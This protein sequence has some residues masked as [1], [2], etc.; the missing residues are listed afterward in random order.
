MTRLPT[1]ACAAFVG[2]DWAAA[3]PAVCLQAAGAETRE[4]RLLVHTPATLDAWVRTLRQRC[5][6]QPM[7]RCLGLNNG[8]L[9][10]ALRKDD[11]LGRCPVNP[12]TLAR[13]REAVAPSQATDAPTD[14]ERQLER[15]LTHRDQRTPLTPQSPAMRPLAPL[16]EPRRRL[17][18]DHGRLPNRLSRTLKHAFPQVLPWVHDHNTALGGDVLTPW[19]TLKAAPLA[20]RTTLERLCRAHHVR[21]PAVIAHRLHAS[22][23]ATPLTT[24]EGVSVPQALLAQALVSPR[25]VTWHAIAACAHAS[26]PHA[27]RHP[28]FPVLAALP[29]AGAVLAPR[30][31]GAFGEPRDR[32]AAADARQTDAGLAPVTAR[33][34]H[35]TWGPWRLPCPTFWRPTFVAWAAASTPQ[36][37]GAR[38]YDQQPRRQGSSHQAAVRALAC[39]GLRLLLRWWQHR[40]PDDE[41]VSLN[42]LQRRGSPLMHNLAHGV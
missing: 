30:L 34:G 33:R 31:L 13:S 11:C 7:A 8:P 3:T 2:L 37:C 1:D 15:R 5:K 39:P 12:R 18:G 14:A 6:G 19:P 26:A 10:A 23:R 42:A 36:A 29:G 9:V 27:H 38:A 24:A 21:D 17:V 20:R 28:D 22:K 16:V 40:P 41:A 25:R 32:D 4:V 35:T